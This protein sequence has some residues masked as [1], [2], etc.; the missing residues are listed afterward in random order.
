MMQHAQR[1]REVE[2][3]VRQRYG[4][5]A[6]EMKAHVRGARQI[7]SR[8]FQCQRAGV[9]D[10]QMRHAR[11]NQHGP[12][13]AAASDIELDGVWRQRRPWEDPEIALEY[14]GALVCRKLF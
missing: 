7:L 10:M 8:R 13:S 5:N 6:R 3:G 12:S 14:L 11:L 2:A 9:K 4:I 1:V